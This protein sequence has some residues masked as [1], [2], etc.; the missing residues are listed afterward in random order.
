MEGRC[1]RAAATWGQD[2]AELLPVQGAEQ[3]GV[4]PPGHW[5]GRQGAGGDGQQCSEARAPPGV[6]C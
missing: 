5:T 6:K 3:G 1:F 2:G 4:Q